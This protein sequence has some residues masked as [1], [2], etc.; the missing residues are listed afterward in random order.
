M[1]SSNQF[2]FLEI[3]ILLCHQTDF[4]FRNRNFESL[5]NGFLC[6]ETCPG[7]RNR[8]INFWPEINF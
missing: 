6:S 5:S 4:C 8:E 3:E 7:N 2:L 1:L